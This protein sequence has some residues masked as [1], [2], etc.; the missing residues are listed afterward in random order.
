MKLFVNINLPRNGVLAL[1][2]PKN[3]LKI[4][5][6]AA[7]SSAFSTSSQAM[8]LRSINSVFCTREL[9]GSKKIRYYSQEIRP[10]ISVIGL[11]S[12]KS[13]SC[14]LLDQAIEELGSGKEVFNKKLL[15]PE[16]KEEFKKLF[17]S[18]PAAGPVLMNSSAALCQIS[19]DFFAEVD[20]NESKTR[21]YSWLS[22]GEFAIAA[23]NGA[24]KSVFAVSHRDGDPLPIIRLLKKIRQTPDEML[25]INIAV[26]DKTSTDLLY[27]LL[28][29]I[30]P[31]KIASYSM[32][33]LLFS[34]EDGN[35]SNIPPRGAYNF[36]PGLMQPLNTPQEK[37]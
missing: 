7:I 5:L 11:S 1:I 31:H 32:G 17:V 12:S 28:K 29:E 4:V 24:K 9:C 16:Q 23:S 26:A 19:C 22:R 18:T 20:P 6:V 21:L 3:F 35:I 15:S 13:V 30:G 36:E 34:P 25:T 10:K 33:F 27:F 8:N 2:H 37:E 14:D